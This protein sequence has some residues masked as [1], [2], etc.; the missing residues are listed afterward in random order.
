LEFH[1]IP[2]IKLIKKYGTPLKFH[3]LPLISKNIIQAK[4]WFKEA[5]EKNN[6]KN[7]YTFSYPTKASH[8]SFVLQEA[9]KN[10]ISLEASYAYDLDI[11]KNLHERKQIKKDIEVI[12]NGFKTKNYLAN[13][14]SLIND[15]FYNVLPVLDNTAEIDILEKKINFPFKIGIRIAT[16]EE[17]KIEFQTSRLGIDHKKVIAFYNKKIKNKPK[18]KLKMIHFFASTA[19]QDTPYYWKELFKCLKIYA[20]LKKIAPELEALNIGGGFP[21]KDSFSLLL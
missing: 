6:Y 10:N 13:I 7:K 8:F 9:L 20:N 12:C 4:K 2:L 15:G 3:Y 11:V 16:D 1:G 18:I 19:I 17:S 21:T 14:S 5:F